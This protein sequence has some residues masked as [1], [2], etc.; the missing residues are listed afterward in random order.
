M[1]TGKTIPEETPLWQIG[2]LTM[3]E[4]NMLDEGMQGMLYTLEDEDGNEQEFEVLGEMEYNGAEYC[5]LIPYY[6]N[7][8]ELLQDD[9]EFVILKRE[10]VDGEEMLCTIEDD[11]EYDAVGNLFLQELSDLY[12]EDGDEGADVQ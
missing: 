1:K 8:E 2:V 4:E 12:D 7:E 9:G 6:E 11:D 3:A 5:A 10:V